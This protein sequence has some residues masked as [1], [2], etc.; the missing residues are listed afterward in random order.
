[1]IVPLMVK[2]PSIPKGRNQLPYLGSWEMA[3]D[4]VPGEEFVGNRISVCNNGA[5]NVAAPICWDFSWDFSRLGSSGSLLQPI[6]TGW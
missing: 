1:M 3:F 2:H 4:V 6:T 5:D